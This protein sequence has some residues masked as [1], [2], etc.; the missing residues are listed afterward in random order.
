MFMPFFCGAGFIL[1]TLNIAGKASS[2]QLMLWNYAYIRT[3][4][5]LSSEKRVWAEF[6]FIYF[7]IRCLI[8]S[9]CQLNIYLIMLPQAQYRY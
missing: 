2:K 3:Y 8:I 7:N 6:C 9:A 1:I 5:E 4:A